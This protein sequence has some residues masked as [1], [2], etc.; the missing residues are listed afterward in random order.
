M[1]TPTLDT[2]Q[3]HLQGIENC[4]RQVLQILPSLEARG[5]NHSIMTS[6]TGQGTVLNVNKDY[7]R[8]L[9]GRGGSNFFLENAVSKAYA[10][11]CSLFSP[12]EDVQM[13]PTISYWKGKFDN[14]VYIGI[15]QQIMNI[16]GMIKNFTYDDTLTKEDDD[17]LS[18]SFYDPKTI[19]TS[20]I[21]VDVPA[22]LVMGIWKAS[23]LI[24]N[25]NPAGGIHQTIFNHSSSIE[26]LSF[27]LRL[28]CTLS[29]VSNTMP[30][31]LMPWVFTW[32]IRP[33]VVFEGGTWNDGNINHSI[34]GSGWLQ[35]TNGGMPASWDD[36]TS[37]YVPI[38][39]A[40][41]TQCTEFVREVVEKPIETTTYENSFN[42]S[43]QSTN[44]TPNL[45]IS[46]T[47][48]QINKILKINE[49]VNIANGG[50][51]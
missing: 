35:Y 19:F 36:V 40:T 48:A 11:Y 3:G 8:G 26:E 5:D 10:N 23:D 20:M 34:V 18:M 43:V 29:Q 39:R 24:K 15:G 14:E 33:N 51:I 30:S 46:L 41:L 25:S 7:I 37:W 49:Q 4:L 32:K 21:L 27:L 9:L 45:T 28:K 50:N 1:R 17:P 12:N 42:I 16:N 6:S 44:M 2:S 22:L 47:N 31:D 38:G 13:K